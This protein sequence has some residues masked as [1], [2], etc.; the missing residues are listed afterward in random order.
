MPTATDPPDRGFMVRGKQ[1]KKNK[2]I[3]G[4]SMALLSVLIGIVAG[5]GAVVFR[6]LIAF[7]HNLLFLGKFSLFYDA[8]THTG[9]SPW[10]IFIVL[11][12]VLG[13]FGVAFLV[14][15]FAPEAKGHGVPEVMDAVYY[16]RGIIRPVVALIKSLASA[17]SIGSGGAI[18]REGPI[19]Q[20]G[21]SFGSTIG[22]IRPMPAWQRITLIAA[23]AG[24]GI[25]ATFNT[26]VG[27]VLFAVE[28]I[29]HEV[30]AR[31]LVP[32]AISTATATYIGR[33]FFG[34]HPSFVIPKFEISFFHLTQPLVLLSYVG[35]G[36]LMGAVST[37]FIKAIYGMED[38]FD[39]RI[40]GNYYTRHM[41]GM[42][43]VGIMMY[44]LLRY[45]GHYYIEGVGYATV[46]DILMGVLSNPFLLLILFV[47]KLLATSLTLGSGASGGI[48]SPA[49]Y[50][51]AT[52]GGLYGVILNMLFPALQV[53]PPAFAVAG[54]AGVVGG[55]TGAAMA[56][57]VMIFE[58]TLDYN[59]ILPL[60]ITV[61]ISYG[62][63]K[64]LSPESI[65]TL[66]LVR[67]GHYMPE[68][69]RKSSEDLKRARQLML[70]PVIT[71]PA[72][73]T[74][75]DFARNIATSES[76]SYFLVRENNK[77]CGVVS[78]QEALRSLHQR[79]KRKTL[80]EIASKSYTTVSE[81]AT[82]LDILNH[83]YANQAP[84][85]L[86]LD[87]KALTNGDLDHVI[88]L[89]TKEELTHLSGDTVELFTDI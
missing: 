24:G 36:L 79:E 89:I 26:P 67:R 12:P 33:L 58:M 74:L 37:L 3:S 46:Q 52:L 78:K 66:K 76:T 19:I 6:A 54:M 71:L 60:T 15:N 5:L 22:Q 86:V 8:N 73:M 21:S 56:A 17:I 31:T 20:I 63:R 2:P 29:L 34:T 42:L 1:V 30:S 72:S 61:A 48:F 13:A 64:F 59:V 51:G 38:F 82:F 49:L 50:L 70:T 35:L 7:F 75:V 68:A 10:G 65:Y 80:G 84:V 62:L 9:V 14:K 40:P 88:G 81:E 44:L 45:T 69:M 83:L 41:L 27:G 23:G 43:L 32:V 55:A 53:T 4:L 18:G 85:A 28:I 25:A 87:N 39:K 47:L 16:K 11:V 77:V 57:I